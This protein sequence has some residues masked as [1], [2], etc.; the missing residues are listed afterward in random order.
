MNLFY[1]YLNIAVY[2]KGRVFDKDRL[3]ILKFGLH[4]RHDLW[5]SEPGKGRFWGFSSPL[6]YII[7]YLIEAL[8]CRISERF[9]IEKDA[10][11]SFF[12]SSNINLT[13]SYKFYYNSFYLYYIVPIY[14]SYQ[15]VPFG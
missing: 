15:D 14:L 8:I 9:C 7:L 2:Q 11:F 13:V 4:K 5:Y 12:C 1:E 3:V 10:C 6:I